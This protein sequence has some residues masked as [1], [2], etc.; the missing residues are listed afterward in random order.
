MVP[1]SNPKT[2]VPGNPEQGARENPSKQATRTPPAAS[3]V[4][5]AKEN[6]GAAK[7]ALSWQI[8]LHDRNSDGEITGNGRRGN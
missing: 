4:T 3:E 8:G 6:V 7:E 5:E 2:C 1:V